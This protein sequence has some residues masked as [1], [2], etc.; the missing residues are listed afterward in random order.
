MTDVNKILK[1]VAYD[2]V[3]I[4]SIWGL[5]NSLNYVSNFNINNRWYSE[6]AIGTS[7]GIA[8]GL[9]FYLIIKYK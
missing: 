2:I 1:D 7:R 8:I 4:T 5:A 6:L 9:S 3:A